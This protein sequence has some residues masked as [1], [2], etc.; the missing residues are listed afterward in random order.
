MNL[1]LYIAF[2]NDPFCN[3]EIKKDLFV[4]IPSNSN[5]FKYRIILF[6]HSVLVAPFEIIFAI[7]GS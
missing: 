4:F 5:S 1:V 2:S 6:I 7:I 3:T